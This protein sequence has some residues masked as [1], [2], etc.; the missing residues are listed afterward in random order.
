MDRRYRGG[1]AFRRAPNV[2]AVSA[3]VVL[4]IAAACGGPA[5]P[6]G[7]TF[8][9][10]VPGDPS[11]TAATPQPL[12]EATVD[13]SSLRATATPIAAVASAPT[14][15]ATAT[16]RPTAA[17]TLTAIP[18]PIAAPT[19]SAAPTP[20]PVTRGDPL[21]VS[22]ELAQASVK[23]GGPIPI[24]VRLSNDGDETITVVRPLVI[25]ALVYLTV[26]DADGVQFPFLGPSADRREFDRDTFVELA[27]G[28]SIDA[29]YDLAVWFP[30]RP[31]R[32]TLQAE[33]VNLDDGGR[34]G[35]SAIV[36]PRDAGLFSSR[37]DLTVEP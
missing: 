3:L 8:P 33:Y 21:R 30:F 31:G 4:F 24:V 12:V 10:A 34:F 6:T 23:S 37:L 16:G 11:P 1:R 35:L 7:A 27:G 2:Q 25:P 22:L 29:V 19:P 32:F 36:T 14:A 18:T 13:P 17:P 26:E 15:S 20:D 28:A 9:T 5:A